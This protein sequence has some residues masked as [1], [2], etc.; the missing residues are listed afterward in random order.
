M[1]V[2]KG[3][4][5]I[6]ARG[7][8][9]STKT[10]S[11]GPF[12]E[13]SSTKWNVYRRFLVWLSF[14]TWFCIG[15]VFMGHFNTI[16][17]RTE[18]T[19]VEVVG[20]PAEIRS[21]VWCVRVWFINK[22]RR[23]TLGR[24][25]FFF[26]YSFL[27]VYLFISSTPVCVFSCYSTWFMLNT[28]PVVIDCVLCVF[29]HHSSKRKQKV[30]HHIQIVFFFIHFCIFYF[31]FH[32]NPCMHAKVIWCSIHIPTDGTVTAIFPALQEVN[33]YTCSARERVNKSPP[34]HP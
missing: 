1:G 26:I 9:R 20:K 17:D 5:D 15:C 32:Q 23:S 11:A 33:N 3:G 6:E 29:V 25:L 22:S 24:R 13:F 21:L 2:G 14:T 10:N 16:N 19:Q 12:R 8:N 28:S 27:H 30:Q 31:S 34:R 7:A 18:C 4:G